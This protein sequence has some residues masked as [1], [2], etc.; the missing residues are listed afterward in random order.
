MENNKEMLV[1]RL[2]E[3][4][5]KIKTRGADYDEVNIFNDVVSAMALNSKSFDEYING[6]IVDYFGS[7]DEYKLDEITKEEV[8]LRDD[9]DNYISN[10]VNKTFT[11]Y[12]KAEKLR[13]DFEYVHGGDLYY[14]TVD[15]LK[16]FYIDMEDN[17]IF[18]Q[19]LVNEGANIR[20]NEIFDYLDIDLN[21]MDL[22]DVVDEVKEY[23]NKDVLEKNETS[24]NKK[25]NE[26]E[27]ER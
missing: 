26:K 7:L 2:E 10:E 17:V 18:I 4:V 13:F 19:S 20:L 25:K 23:L 9:F 21:E 1:Y 3:I 12:D 15:N 11:N 5:K 16:E 8:G 22:K 27:L 6:Y 24:W 14:D